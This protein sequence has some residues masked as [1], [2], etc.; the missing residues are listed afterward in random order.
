MVK[1]TLINKVTRELIEGRTSVEYPSGV[2]EPI[3]SL[4]PSL[5]WLIDYK[6]DRPTYD[7]LTQKLIRTKE[8]TTIP[9]PDYPLFSQYFI[10][11]DVIDLSAQELEDLEEAEAGNKMI[12][13][14]ENGKEL[15]LKAGKKIW[16]KKNKAGNLTRNQARK[17]MRWFQPTYINLSFGDWNEADKSILDAVLIQ[18]LADENDNTMTNIYEFLRDEIALYLNDYDL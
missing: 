17:L 15:L 7:P 8:V 5:E 13:H 16:R 1:A 11:F 2:I 10:Y 12:L 4:D 3:Q 9:H 6:E 18:D 14:Q